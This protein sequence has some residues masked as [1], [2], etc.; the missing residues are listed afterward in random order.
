VSNRKTGHGVLLT[1]E[2]FA[3]VY[4]YLDREHSFV[5]SVEEIGKTTRIGKQLWDRIQEIAVEVDFTP[6]HM[7]IAPVPPT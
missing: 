3:L 4:E 7:P 6:T 5:W 2:D 1:E